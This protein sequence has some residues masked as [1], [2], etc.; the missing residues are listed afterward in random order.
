MQTTETEALKAPAEPGILDGQS[1]P[2]LDDGSAQSGQAM[3]KD[4]ETQ[5]IRDGQPATSAEQ[6]G[7]EDEPPSQA[8]AHADDFSPVDDEEVNA[9]VLPETPPPKRIQLVLWNEKFPASAGCWVFWREAGF[10]CRGKLEKG[11]FTATCKGYGDAQQSQ[12]VEISLR[13]CFVSQGEG[14]AVMGAM[15]AFDPQQAETM[16]IDIVGRTMLPVWSAAPV[17]SAEMPDAS[18]D[19]ETAPV[20]ATLDEE[21]SAVAS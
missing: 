6:A 3:P 2:S 17:S 14:I 20:S 8:E 16:G 18:A 15:L 7:A 4:S 12:P 1:P 5:L 21:Q 9:E 11:I 19:P 13:R 10:E